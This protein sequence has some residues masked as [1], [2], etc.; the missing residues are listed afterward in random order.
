MV[1]QS[2]KAVLLG[3]R[4]LACHQCARSASPR[5][6]KTSVPLVRLGDLWRG[7]AEHATQ[8]SGRERSGYFLLGDVQLGIIASRKLVLAFHYRQCE[9]FS[10]LGHLGVCG[11]HASAC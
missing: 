2:V 10:D 11:L 8:R 3:G 9:L 7:V 4:V 1:R 5:S 6:A